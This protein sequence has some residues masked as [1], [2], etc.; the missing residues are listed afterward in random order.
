MVL[1]DL[2]TIV[3]L[4]PIIGLGIAGLNR[5]HA[6]P[7][8]TPCKKEQCWPTASSVEY[9]VIFSAVWF[10]WTICISLLT[11]NRPLGI[12]SRAFSRVRFCMIVW[13]VVIGILSRLFNP[14]RI[15]T[16]TIGVTQDLSFMPGQ[17]RQPVFPPH[18][19][20]KEFG[21][22]LLRFRQWS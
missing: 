12:V 8:G 15:L 20:V 5:P 9:P 19:L 7:Q 3:Q 10:Q 22:I 14:R 2:V 1:P 11:T 4:A 21:S 17:R 13:S 6:A 18:R 16:E